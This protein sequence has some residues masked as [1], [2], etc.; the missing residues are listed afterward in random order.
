MSSWFE[1]QKEKFVDLDQVWSISVESSYVYFLGIN[2]ENQGFPY[3]EDNKIR[4][5]V[6]VMKKRCIT[7]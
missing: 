2:G 5:L 6:R 3:V 4:Q 7:R 1:I